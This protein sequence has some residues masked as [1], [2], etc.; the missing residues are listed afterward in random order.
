MGL[1]FDLAL[2]GG[3]CTGIALNAALAEMMRR[4]HETRRLVGTSAGSIAAVLVAAGYTGEE[5]LAMS[6]RRTAKGLPLFSEYI[7]EPIVPS[8]PNAD[9]DF[10]EVELALRLPSGLMRRLR[11]ARSIVDF[12]ERGGFVTGTGF[13]DWLSGALERKHAGL[14]LMTLGEFYAH[15]G[16]HLTLIVTDLT[17]RRVR[18]L[19]HITA[20]DV[21]VVWATRMSIGVPLYFTEVPWR[22]EWGLYLGEPMTDNVM[23]DGGLMTNLPIG[24]ILPSGN[25]LM[26]RIMGEP[27]PAVRPLGSSLDPTLAV[28]GAPPRTSQMSA[29]S[30]TKVGRRIAALWDAL[31]QGFDMSLAEFEESA[32]VLRLPVRGFP[33]SEFDM[34]EERAEA[35]LQAATAQARVFFD[36][37]ER[38]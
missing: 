31:L 35:L 32:R 18:P 21:P 8:S 25:T 2:E 12:F 19:N 5:L 11:S 10:D 38:N 1:A 22:E 9:F 7:A 6:L 14:S 15:T 4:G 37:L 24:F 26:A 34:S 30:D 33:P 28:P 27:D 3:G 13:I 23:V 36:E 20:P 29:L 17:H 16:V